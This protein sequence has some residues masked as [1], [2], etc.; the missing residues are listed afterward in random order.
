MNVQF[1]TSPGVLNVM[2]NKR[3]GADS[4]QC[5]AYAILLSP[6]PQSEN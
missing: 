1:T 6:H 4:V 3:Y 5:D 2:S